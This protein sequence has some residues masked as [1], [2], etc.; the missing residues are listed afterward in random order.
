MLRNAGRN[1]AALIG[2]FFVNLAAFIVCVTLFSLG[3]GLLVIVVGLFVLVGCLGAA[4][5]LAQANKSVLAYAGVDL[6]ATHYPRT[7]GGFGLL[8]RLRDPQS[9]RDLIHVPIALRAQHLLVLRGGELGVRRHRRR[10]LLV[11]GRL[12]ARRQPGA[13]LPARFP[14]SVRRVGRST[15]RSA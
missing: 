12:P 3:A 14:E 9:W 4:G 13:G 2:L 8:R 5:A 10:P 6:P 15:R 7:G 11:L 1:L